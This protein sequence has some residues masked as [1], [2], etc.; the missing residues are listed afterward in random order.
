MIP[1]TATRAKAYATLA[2]AF[3]YPDHDLCVELKEGAFQL[4]LC[5]C[6]SAVTAGAGLIKDMAVP[7][8]MEET[9]LEAAYIDAFELSPCP[10]YEGAHL[11]ER[12]R[13]EILL[14][15]KAFYQHF[16]LAVAEGL[17]EPEDHVTA[18]LDF[19]HFL[20]SKQAEA[21]ATGRDAGPYLRAQRDFLDRHL[22]RWLPIQAAA[23]ERRQILPFYRAL[24]RL[25]AEFAVADLGGVRAAAPPEKLVV[26]A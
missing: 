9:A 23:A 6:V 15:V 19:M 20:V 14:E 24:C 17:N 5:D 18:E 3:A 12:D 16:G 25:A 22:A 4:D 11:R 7:P 8:D 10:L 21:E 2:E 13:S 1:D 26:G